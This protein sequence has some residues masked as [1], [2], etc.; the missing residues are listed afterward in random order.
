MEPA[1]V[2]HEG[3]AVEPPSAAEQADRRFQLTDLGNAERFAF[4]NAHLL[5]YVHGIGWHIYDGKRWA[6]DSSGGVG[7][8]A[9][10]A[11]R[12]MYEEAQQLED[13][14][15][16]ELVR[17]ALQSE[18]AERL[19][20]LVRLAEAIQ[21]VSATAAELD[22]DPFLLNVDNGTIDLRS[23]RLL[24]HDRQHLITKLAPVAHDPEASCPNWEAFIRWALLGRD[25]LVA[26]VQRVLG[27]WLTASVAEQAWFLLHG[28]GQN[29][30]TT[31]LECVQEMMGDYA[32]RAM[33]EVVLGKSSH[34]TEVAVLAG[35]RLALAIEPDMGKPFRDGLLKALTGESQF[36]ARRMHKDPFTFPVTFKLVIAA[37]H[38][39]A[40]HDDSD[41]FWRRVR[42]IPFE[43]RIEDSKRDRNLKEKLHAEWPGILAWRV[44]GAVDWFAHGLGS[45]PEVDAATRQYREEED[46]VRRF[47]EEACEFGADAWALTGKLYEAFR[48]WCQR[49]GEHV[50]PRPAFR[51]RLLRMEGVKSAARGYGRGLAGIKLRAEV[52][53]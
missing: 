20:A 25:D 50:I 27:Y 45:A 51:T 9:A 5:R 21:G 2:W 34:P 43:N 17:H 39:P 52:T 19:G 12:S 48:D 15:R 16:R 14:A 35:S 40:V 37:N 53:G 8:L 29:G 10:A 28:P 31:L 38:L 49:N 33:P 44:R 3:E 1:A 23:G 30:K 26:Y 13:P 11:V 4:R 46:L 24:P 41:G 7:R 6:L 18:K 32:V 42:L 47:T 36:T 22:R